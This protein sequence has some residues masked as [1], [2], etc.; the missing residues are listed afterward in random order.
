[1][2]RRRS[3]ELQRQK[4]TMRNS[5]LTPSDMSARRGFVPSLDGLRAVSISIVLLAHFVDGKIFPG[6]LGV[7][8][9]FI[10]SGF[11][12]TRLLLAEQDVTGTVALKAFYARR[13]CRLYPVIIVFCCTVTLMDIDLNRPYNFLEPTSAL[14]YF[15]NYY[16]V[17][18]DIHSIHGQ[19]P[20]GIFWSLSIEEHFY[21]LF[22]VAFMLLK[23]N[24]V[25]L[26]WLLSALC[27]GCLLLRIAI[28]GL[29]PEY[30]D[31]QIFY[32]LSQYRLD[33]IGFGVILALA[34]QT[35]GGRAALLRLTHPV[36]PI[37][38]VMT[39]VLCLLVRDPWFR[40]TWRYTL[41][42]VSIVVLVTA[43][44]FGK[45]Y[46]FTQWVLNTTLLRW[47]G[48]LSYSLYVW[49]E[50]VAS[51]LP[52]EHL[53][54]W[55][56]GTISLVASFIVASISYYAIERPFL[57]LRSHFREERRIRLA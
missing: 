46:R 3:I 14:G 11:L 27:L 34:C 53:P 20:F 17:Y 28:A 38:A 51:F 2:L 8:F 55:Q 30:L 21:I 6:G 24:P 47:I 12:I 29:H 25:R 23:G 19:M 39:I 31:T 16:Y 48:R 1:M 49:H 4:A 54:T 56:Q 45:D 41:L 44:L 5:Y 9:F 32:A 42:G 33:S 36:Y 40:E 43:V 10:I 37:A 35:M 13:I 52:I 7:Y 26:M 57:S 22:P 50:G 18:L 15:A